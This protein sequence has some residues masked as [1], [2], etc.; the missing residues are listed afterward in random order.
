MAECI[1]TD[2]LGKHGKVLYCGMK[3]YWPCDIISD[4]NHYFP[5]E[6]FE[7]IVNILFVKLLPVYVN[8]KGTAPPLHHSEWNAASSVEIF[9][10]TEGKILKEKDIFLYFLSVQ[11][12]FPLFF[13]FTTILR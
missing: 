10:S 2:F 4:T 9:L 5:I 12:F 1:V 7:R 3:G 8:W 6:P 13:F 11:F